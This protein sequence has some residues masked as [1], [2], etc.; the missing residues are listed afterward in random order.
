MIRIIEDRDVQALIDRDDALDVIERT[1]RAAASG[2]AWV[3]QP[4]AMSLKGPAAA[5]SS[6]KIK[7]ALIES[8]GVA[9][10]RCIG[11]GRDGDGGSYVF[12]FEAGTAKPTALVAEGWL[13]RLRTAMTGLV[14]CR[15]LAPSNPQRLVLVGTGRIAE[16]FVRIV[17][18]AFPSLPIVLASRSSERAAQTAERWQPLTRNPLSAA[19]KMCDALAD[20]DIVVTLSDAQERLFAATD[21][22]SRSLLCAMGGRHEFESDVLEAASHLVVDEID[23]VCTAGNGAHWIKSGQMTRQELED[24]VDATIGEVLIGKTAIAAD[25]V[26]LAIIQGMAVCDI[27]LAQLAF[28]RMAKRD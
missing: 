24:S 15:A 18:L 8:L 25:G 6:F 22:K 13:H 2:Q 16:E 21:L 14:T 9:G 20:A 23:F 12:L 7:G 4:A 3:S 5:G 19:A 27:A 10:F 1:Y 28:D 11:D 26:V 17:D